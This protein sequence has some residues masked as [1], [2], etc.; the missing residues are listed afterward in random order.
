M[1]EVTLSENNSSN[2]IIYAPLVFIYGDGYGPD[3]LLH[4]TTLSQFYLSFECIH[5][6]FY[7]L[8]KIYSSVVWWITPIHQCLL[9]KF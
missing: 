7:K 3:E 5:Y 2:S 1:H 9:F 8:K 4:H 6:D